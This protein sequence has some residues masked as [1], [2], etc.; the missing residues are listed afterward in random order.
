MEPTTIDCNRIF[1]NEIDNPT[2]SIEALV[3]LCK[4]LAWQKQANNSEGCTTMGYNQKAIYFI[5]SELSEIGRP[6][7]IRTPNDWTKTSSVTI[8]PSA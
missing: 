8:T 2:K 1:K 3:Y 5:K 6:T 7:G 4:T